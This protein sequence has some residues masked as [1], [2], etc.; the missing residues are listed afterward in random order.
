MPN[1]SRV[2]LRVN[3]IGYTYLVLRYLLGSGFIN[4]YPADALDV[5]NRLDE[6]KLD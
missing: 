2:S 4:I 3:Q 1:W 5:G 6:L